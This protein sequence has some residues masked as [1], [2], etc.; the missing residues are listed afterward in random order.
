MVVEMKSKTLDEYR[1]EMLNKTFGWLTVLDVFR[2]EKTHNRLA[3]CKCKC[4][5]ITIKEMRKVYNG[6]TTSCGCYN[7][8]KEKANKLRQSWA[9][10]PE[11]CKSQA[12]KLKQYYENHPETSETISQKV[13]KFYDENPD[14][15]LARGKLYSEW[16]A[17]NKDKLSEIGKTHSQYYKD[18]P[19]VGATAG[20]KIAQFYKDNPDA[21]KARVAKRSETMKNNPDI[22]NII[23]EKCREWSKNNKDK[24]REIAIKNSNFYKNIRKLTDY[25]ELIEW[26]HPDQIDDLLNGN[27]ASQEMIKT[28]CPKC[29]DYEEH[30]LHNLFL[31]KSGKL[32]VDSLPLCRKCYNSN[33]SSKA[34]QELA[35]YVSTLY[36]GDVIKNDRS[37]ISP[38]ELDLYYPE[39]KIAIEFNGDYWHSVQCGKSKDY[40]LNKYKLCKEKGIRLISIFEHDYKFN[41]DK[42][43][44]L[45]NDIF[46]GHDKLYARNCE[47]KQVS[48]DEKLKFIN[49]Y[50]F[51]GDSKYST[52]S[53][54]LYYNDELISCMTFGKLRGQNKLRDNPHHYELIRFITKSGITVI[55]GASKLFKHFIKDYNPEYILCYSDNDFFNGDIYSKLGFKLK[56]L[57]ENSIDY[58][59]VNNSNYRT[60][61][62]TM[63][64]KLLKQYP[65]YNNIEING[66]KENYIMEDLGYCKV[67][68]CGNSIW[69]WHS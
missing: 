63:P 60:R 51:D 6:H 22:Q 64:Y 17:N 43:L 47:I 3:K 58:I 69:E 23:T 40:H 37:I 20:K 7:T 13:S 45:L 41:R 29:G 10:D 18:N 38:Y 67:Y 50:H 49:K 2:D 19:E 16:A 25:S 52:I 39:K 35:D 55:G 9:N 30:S 54:G 42:V 56:S 31:V 46:I 8:S 36:N 61:H 14:K 48:N 34:E 15:A 21:L 57:G 33:T 1:Q 53:Y 44:Q 24:I 65:E 66:S 5:N 11:R 62:Q 28:R 59:W 4:G 32:K 12:N 68:R 27:I 26:V